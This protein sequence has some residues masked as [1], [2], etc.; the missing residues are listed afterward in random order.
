MRE[1]FNVMLS[2]S[3]V[4]KRRRKLDEMGLL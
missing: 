1:K 3:S 2:R 4:T